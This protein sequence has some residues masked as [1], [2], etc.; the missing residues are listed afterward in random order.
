ME[1][2]H[3]TVG[4]FGVR[5]VIQQAGPSPNAPAQRIVLDIEDVQELVLELQKYL[6]MA[7]VVRGSGLL[8]EHR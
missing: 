5:A 1:R 2:V 3:L 7:D 4:S 8:E 6:K